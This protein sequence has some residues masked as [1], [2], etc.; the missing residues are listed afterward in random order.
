MC[1]HIHRYDVRI[2]FASLVL[3]AGISGLLSFALLAAAI[4]SEY[5]YIIEM[6][7]LNQSGFEDM[8]SHSG[9]WR[10]NEGGKVYSFTADYSIYSESE[11]YILNLHSVIVV[12]L[13]LSLV[14]LVF[15]GICGLVSSLA[16]SPVLLV[17][18][19]SYF[20]TC[21]L[22]TLSGMVLYIIYSYLALAETERLLGP[23]GL[24]GVSTSFGW[25]TILAWLSYGLEVLSGLLLLTAAH[26]V[27]PDRPT[28]P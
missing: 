16:Q 17:C 5:W 7:P 24:V 27:K 11:L 19:A 23:E 28:V 14:L 3:T 4:G 10:S 2:T 6:T 8:N 20:F 12:V 1:T 26:K 21:S 18:T 15:G 22:L 25:S 9:L 13:P